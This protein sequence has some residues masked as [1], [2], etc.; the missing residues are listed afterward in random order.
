MTS[1]RQFASRFFALFRKGRLEQEMDEEML[2]HVEMLTEENVQRGMSTKEARC[3]ALREFG[4][5]DQTKEVYRD[6]RGLP[7]IETL[8]QDLRYGLRVLAKS[9]GFSAVAIITLGLGIAVN[10]TIFSFVS[11][12]LLRKPPVRDPDH[13]MML[14]S[15]NPGQVWAADRAP[16]SPPDFLD[17]K[18][19]STSYSGF[20]ASNFDELTLSGG[21]EPERVGGA[22]VSANYFDVLGVAPTLG[23]TFVTGED[24]AGHERVV[25]LSEGLWRRRFAGD[26]HM[27]GRNVK[28]NGED[29]VLIGI[30]PS[31]FQLWSFPAK[32]WTPLVF[33]AT[34]LSEEGR[35]ARSLDVFARLKPGVSQSQARAE[36]A[37]IVARL[38]SAHPE[39]NKGWG[40]NLMSL[41]EF[42]VE[43]ANVLT[44]TVFL[45]ATVAFVLLIACANLANLLLAR[46][47]TRQREFT[48]RAALGAGRVRLARQLLSE[49]LLLSLA[50]GVVGLLCTFWGAA[51]LRA[52]INYNEFATGMASGIHVDGR[53]LIF[54]LAVSV[55]S[56]MV[57][58][59]AP[60]L[61]ISRPDLNSGLKENS[62]SATGGRSRHRVQSF[63]VVAQLA[64]SLI[65]LVGAGL[66]AK[67]FIEELR[68]TLGI[69]PNRILTASVSLSGQAY[70]DPAQQAA[71][72]QKVLH[73][74]GSD[75]QVQSAAAT[76]DLPLTFADTT[77]FV[78]EGRP[79]EDPANRPYVGHYFVS[80]NYFSTIQASLL[81]GRDFTPSDNDDSQPVSIVSRAFAEKYLPHQ[82]PLGQHL[83]VGDSEST[84]W[85]EIVGVVGDIKD[86]LGQKEEK[87][88]IFEPFL[89]HPV[90]TMNLV[91]RTHSDPAVYVASMRAAVWEVDKDQ[92]VN[93]VRTMDQV[94]KDSRAGDD[95]MTEMMCTFSGLALLMAAVGIYGLL[96]YLVEQRT[97][98]IGIRMALGA[99]GSE[100]LRLVF[101]NAMTMVL[102]GVGIG[103]VVSLALPSLFSAS[104]NDFHV[105]SFW[106][107][108]LTP[109]AVILVSLAA[110][111]L[112][113]RRAARVDPIVALRYE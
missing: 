83:K 12:V 71:F 28:V 103:F 67:N 55:M 112:P 102:L 16:V 37:T 38:A 42:I 106:V 43:D 90:G 105:R 64:L 91:V 3:A 1:L 52:A 41:Q 9:P 98:E 14:R 26:P 11:A 48:I 58:G 23:R 69:N 36:L 61:R 7:M 107:L 92:A 57:F 6:Q 73:R 85:A 31:S 45:M 78:L 104:F 47:S 54:T 8:L 25:L 2:G 63:L 34:Q 30:I 72:F 74:L 96:A 56:A 81:Q 88:H 53:V 84:K 49:C 59:F 108:A 68:A 29:F 18:A 111:Y 44:A 79:P 51:A 40:A 80:P 21:S 15:R 65:L 110:C 89:A 76:S 22:R 5:V 94:V 10:T 17:W 93:T 4:G 27:I 101:R 95:L 97:H 39:S 32:L 113:A 75:S 87:P 60:A 70:K 19:Q 35:K 50:G 24:R 82:N 66:F 33:T 62:R 77:H 13:V 20:A 99:R 46:N 109:C 86:F 100:V